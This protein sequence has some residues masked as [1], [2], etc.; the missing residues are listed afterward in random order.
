[1]L[2]VSDND[3]FNRL[4]EFMGQEAFNETLK[5]KGYRNL[6]IVHRLSIPYSSEENSITPAIQFGSQKSLLKV[7]HYAEPDRMEVAEKS[8]LYTQEAQKN[9]SRI[10]APNV[11]I[12]KG[13]GY[14]K[15]DEIINEPFDFTGKNFYA[16][17]E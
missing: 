3:A 15:G 6:R 1:M 9:T 2:L 16:L 14:Q 11:S 10:Y 8:Q 4:Y 13:K 5:S 7:P 17:T 12:R